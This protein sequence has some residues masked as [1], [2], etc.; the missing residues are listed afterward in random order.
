MTTRPISEDIPVYVLRTHR[1]AGAGSASPAEHL[2]RGSEPVQ[3]IRIDDRVFPVAVQRIADRPAF[4]LLPNGAGEPEFHR[5][6]RRR[7]WASLADAALRRAAAPVARTLAIAAASPSELPDHQEF[8]AIQAA[9]WHHSTGADIVDGS[10]P[11]PVL[12]RYRELLTADH[13]VATSTMTEV[14]SA[15]DSDAAVV[16]QRNW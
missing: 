15:G 8:A 9:V 6:F 14:Y 7:S 5:G 4:R 13:V 16:V 11:A 2:T 3:V 12:A 10:A 1:P